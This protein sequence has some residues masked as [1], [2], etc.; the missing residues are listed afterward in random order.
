MCG[1]ANL[2]VFGDKVKPTVKEFLNNVSV[3]MIHYFT[4]IRCAPQVY[5]YGNQHQKKLY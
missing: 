1:V 2:A 5:G 3:G 4:V